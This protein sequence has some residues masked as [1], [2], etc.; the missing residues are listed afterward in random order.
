[1]YHPVQKGRLY[2]H[3]PR[4]AGFQCTLFLPYKY[5]RTR[6]I[7]ETLHGQVDRVS[8]PYAV[9][10]PSTAVVNTITVEKTTYISLNSVRSIPPEEN[11]YLWV[12]ILEAP[13]KPGMTALYAHLPVTLTAS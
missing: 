6:S 9:L 8:F 7:N 12:V 10:I 13:T 11:I 4:P 2:M 1:M 5:G 3:I